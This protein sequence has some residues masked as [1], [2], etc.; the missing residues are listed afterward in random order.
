MFAMC[1]FENI[2]RFLHFSIALDMS[3]IT[4]FLAE[5]MNPKKSASENILTFSMS[6]KTYLRPKLIWSQNCFG[7][8]TFLDPKV[9]WPKIFCG[10]K[11]F[12]ANNYLGPKIF[13]RPI[14]CLGLGDFHWRL[15]IKL[16][17]PNTLDSSLM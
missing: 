3:R 6:A 15:G 13:F 12:Q 9:F 2:I 17:K 8:A 14:I 10:P 1:N 11:N 4:H 5:I 16:F 7:P